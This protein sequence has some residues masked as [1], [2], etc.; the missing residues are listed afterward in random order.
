MNDVQ[1]TRQIIELLR[2]R[3]SPPEWAAFAELRSQTGYGGQYLDFYAMNMWASNRH[4]KIAYEV[5]SS[6]GDFSREL[7]QP[8]KREFAETVADECY[9]AMPS[10]LVQTD[11]IPEGW[12]L[13]EMTSGGLRI[14]KRAMQRRVEQLPHLFVLSLARRVADPEPELP[15]VIWLNAGQELNEEMLVEAAIGSLDDFKAKHERQVIQEFRRSD[16]FSRLK[17]I[18]NVVERHLGWTFSEPSKLDEWFKENIDRERIELDWR[19]RGL[20]QQL[21]QNVDEILESE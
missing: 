10:G 9:F 20:L 19:T 17:A 7:N 12:G 14:K 2:H 18:T 16:E 11:E 5:K 8:K 3:H 1:T 13:V 21:K 4:I 15:P 6:R